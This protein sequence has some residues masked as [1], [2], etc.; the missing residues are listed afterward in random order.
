MCHFVEYFDVV[1]VGLRALVERYDLFSTGLKIWKWRKVDTSQPLGAE[2]W[3][4]AG[5]GPIHGSW[6]AS[7]SYNSRTV[8]GA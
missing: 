4:L 8:L 3:I 1:F 7:C 2:A 6:M 5:R